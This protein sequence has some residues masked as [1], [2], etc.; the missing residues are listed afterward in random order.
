MLQRLSPLTEFD[1]HA[2]QRLAQQ[3][4]PFK[5]AKGKPLDAEKTRRCLLYLCSGEVRLRDGHQR[6]ERI[7]SDNPRATQPLLHNTSARLRIDTITPCELLCVDIHLYQ[8][9][10]NEQANTGMEVED[11]LVDRNEGL[12]F[13]TIFKSIQDQNLRLP[14][15]PDIAVK[16]HHAVQTAQAGA[17]QIALI[18]QSDPSIAGRLMKC[19]VVIVAQLFVRRQ[20][21]GLPT[22]EQ[23]PACAM[24]NLGELTE[25]ERLAVIQSA[26]AE[27]NA[28]A[29]LLMQ[30]RS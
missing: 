1:Q 6:D 12:L 23:L 30:G 19:D 4:R 20:E 13:E 9:L 14:T 15:L 29:R 16:V 2:R 10:R 3:S 28:M 25:A 27:I 7:R 5:L 11:F 8:M 21:P 24:L 22:L 17:A 26:Q 18:V